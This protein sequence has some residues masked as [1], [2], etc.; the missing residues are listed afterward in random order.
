V[1]RV[2]F[3]SETARVELKKWTSVSPWSVLEFVA[4][5]GE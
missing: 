5:A 1:S 2:H 3:V 4:H